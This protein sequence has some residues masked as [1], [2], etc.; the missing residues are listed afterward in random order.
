MVE[1]YFC[2]N[3]LPSPE[4]AQQP[5]AVAILKTALNHTKNSSFLSLKT[6][7]KYTLNCFSIN[8][9]SLKIFDLAIESGKQRGTIWSFLIF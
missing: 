4:L 2:S 9:Y 6:K 5:L 3:S 8:H 1:T 7:F